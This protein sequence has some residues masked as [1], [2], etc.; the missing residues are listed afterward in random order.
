MA[1]IVP[2][3]GTDENRQLVAAAGLLRSMEVHTTDDQ[4]RL[5][6]ENRHIGGPVN[7]GEVDSELEMLA[8]TTGSQYS[9][10]PSDICYRTDTLSFWICWSN[11]GELGSD[12]REFSVGSAGVTEVDGGTA[13][14]EFTDL[15]DGGDAGDE[16]TDIV[17]G[18]PEPEL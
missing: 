9:V 4:K 2:L 13:V 6:L 18:D 7:H 3:T 8:L 1:R 12:W 15:L 14:D 5:F 16:F 10:F 11:R 17:D